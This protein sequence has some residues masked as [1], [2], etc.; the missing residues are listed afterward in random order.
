MAAN[1]CVY[2]AVWAMLGTYLKKE[3]G[4]TA[5]QVAVPVFWGNILTFIAC[6][7]WGAVSER[8]R[9]ALGVDVTHDDRRYS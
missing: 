9:T 2:Y 4:W 8:G 7:F 6:S 5:A 1:F 3:L